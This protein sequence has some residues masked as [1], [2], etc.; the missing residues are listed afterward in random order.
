MNL[1]TCIDVQSDLNQLVASVTDSPFSSRTR[2]LKENLNYATVNLLF[3]VVF[4]F[5][6]DRSKGNGNISAAHVKQK[7][8]LSINGNAAARVLK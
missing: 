4:V 6:I 2:L 3:G 5:R 8:T 7:M 1:H